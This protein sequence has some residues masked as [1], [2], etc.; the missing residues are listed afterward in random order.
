MCEQSKVINFMYFISSSTGDFLTS[1]FHIL[2]II[3]VSIFILSPNRYLNFP[4]NFKYALK[5]V[6]F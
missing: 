2:S 4:P 3:V 6:K 5:E 1:N